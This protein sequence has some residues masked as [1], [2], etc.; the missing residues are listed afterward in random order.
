VL[1]RGQA[2][3]RRFRRIANIPVSNTPVFIGW[4]IG[5]LADA[6]PGEGNLHLCLRRCSR[7]T[8]YGVL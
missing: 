7:A 6:T 1:D 3:F 2:D 8:R 5:Y 4:F